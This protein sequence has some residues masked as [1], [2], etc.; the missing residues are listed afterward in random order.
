MGSFGRLK[1]P[2][3]LE[4]HHDAARCAAHVSLPSDTVAGMTLLIFD[5]DGVLV[6]SELLANAELADLLTRLGHPMS[7]QQALA[8]FGGRRLQDVLTSAEA[9]LSAPI[10][11]DLAAQAGERLMARLR[12]EL[13]PVAGVRAAIEALGQPRCVASSSPRERLKLS[14][15]VTGLAPLFGAHVFSADQVASGKPAP[16]L[17]LL[18]ARTLG[19]R[20]ADCIV[21]EDSALGIQAA[22][23]AGMAA[24]GFAGASHATAELTEQLG[25]AGADIVIRAMSDLPQAVRRIASP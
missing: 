9:L 8:R 2:A 17:F 3:E 24:I 12:D 7:P 10:P 1:M 13:Q 18:A 21:V 25:E 4:R 20:P 22:R 16:D 23:A 5:C 14:L 11:P 15:A 6:D 19:A